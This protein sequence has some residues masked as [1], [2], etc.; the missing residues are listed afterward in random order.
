MGVISNLNPSTKYRVRMRVGAG[1]WGPI[2]EIKTQESPKF[3]AELC[4]SS[5]YKVEPPLQT[6]KEGIVYGTNEIQFGVHCWEVKIFPTKHNGDETACICIGVSNKEQK[7]HVVVGT[8][9]N[10]GYQKAMIAVKVTL[11]CEENRMLI[12]STGNQDE[13]YQNLPIFPIFPVI[14]NKGSTPVQIQCIFL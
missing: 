9:L 14:Q 6:L 13:I 12:S 5:K 8:T 3:N 1:V 7:K 4:I 2:S 11:N 10:Y